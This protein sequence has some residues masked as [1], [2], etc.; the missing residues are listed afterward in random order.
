MRLLRFALLAALFAA[1]PL[2]HAQLIPSLGVAGGLNFGSL[3][4]AAGADFDQSTGYHIGIFGDVGFGP[5][6]ARVSILYVQAGD[7]EF[8]GLDIPG[9]PDTGDAGV[10][11]VAV[12]VDFQY[13][14]PLPL[15]KPYALFGPEVRFP[16]GDLTDFSGGR[17]VTFALNFGVGAELSAIVGPS[18][19]AE[20]RYGLD[21]TGFVDGGEV[22]G[23]VGT[24][25]DDDTFKVNAFY[26]RLGVG[27]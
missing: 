17:D 6:A 11:F 5:L 12:P 4:D 3:G 9:A 27:L 19:F 10:S 23:G 14:L 2:A 15:L 24:F 22:P 1:A 7:F 20:L 26:L 18:V 21:V 13:G 16:T 8:V 25:S